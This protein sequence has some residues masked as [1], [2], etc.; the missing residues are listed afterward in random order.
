[1]E[2]ASVSAFLFRDRSGSYQP[3]R[4]AVDVLAALHAFDVLAEYRKAPQ[5]ASN[6][7]QRAANA[8]VINAYVG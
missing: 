7:V 6:P 2:F 4:L 5:T 1:M 8:A 3:R